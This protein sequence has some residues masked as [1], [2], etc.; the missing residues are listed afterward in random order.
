MPSL[1]LGFKLLP[2]RCR[3]LYIGAKV[4]ENSQKVEPVGPV[5]GICGI[6]HSVAF[7]GGWQSVCDV[8]VLLQPD[9]I[10]LIGT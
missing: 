8:Y 3:L 5:R 10:G 1:D 2:D 7:C 6:R 4:T 9:L